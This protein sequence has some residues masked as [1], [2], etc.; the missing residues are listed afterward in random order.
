MSSRNTRTVYKVGYDKLR[1]QRF[2]KQQQLG[3]WNADIKLP[4]RIPPVEPW[5]S[6]TPDQKAYRAK[7]L[8]VQCSDD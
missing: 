1:E 2:E 8:A 6:L 7:V 3:I 5:D 4:Q